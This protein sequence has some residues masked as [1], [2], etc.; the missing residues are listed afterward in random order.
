M[1]TLMIEHPFSL[2]E[3]DWFHIAPVGEFA[4][5]SGVR[6]VVDVAAC[7]AMAEDFSKTA[8]G[9]NFPGLL[10]DFDHFSHS[11]DKASEAAGWI[12]ALRAE[13]AEISNL[14]SPISNKSESEISEKKKEPGLWAQIRWS[15][16][17]EAAVRGGRYRLVS[18]VWNRSDCEAVDGDAQRVRPLRLSRVALTNDPNLQGLVPLSNRSE[19]KESMMDYKAKLL[20]LLGLKAGASDAEIGTA[21]SA[22]AREQQELQ[23]RHGA[24]LAERVEEDLRAFAEVIGD[25]VAVRSQLLENREGT[26]ATLRALR[27]PAQ[28]VVANGGEVRPALHNRSVAGV[29]EAVFSAEESPAERAK[30][31][32]IANRA[33]ELQKELGLGHL[34]AF[35]MARGE[36]ARKAAE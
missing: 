5:A 9:P 28:A 11:A 25:A 10:V 33:R 16:V 12:T 2:P 8:T 18:P 22:H 36:L 1:T 4:H 30:A 31:R 21:L 34:E 24:L 35:Q 3:D 26:L 13:P 15:D 14:K 23:Q 27:A 6:Q 17:G 19:Q 32:R 7:R 29:P 20:E